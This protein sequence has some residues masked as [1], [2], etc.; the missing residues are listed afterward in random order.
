M[1]GETQQ[2]WTTH[3]SKRKWDSSE[4][5]WQHHISATYQ[6]PELEQI[7]WPHLSSIK[8]VWN[9]SA[10]SPPVFCQVLNEI[11]NALA[12]CLVHGKHIINGRQEDRSTGH[13]KMGRGQKRRCK[14]NLFQ[15]NAR[16]NICDN[17]FPIRLR[18][19]QKTILRVDKGMGNQ[20]SYT[21]AFSWSKNWYHISE[22]I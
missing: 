20:Y 17:F 10:Y 16:G 7:A 5:R 21:F 6:L 11:M 2:S 1:P 19:F 14:E 13:R 12:Q 15:R 9:S 8:T 18:E 3:G 4:L 22:L